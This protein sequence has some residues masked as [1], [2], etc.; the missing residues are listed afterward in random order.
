MLTSPLKRILYSLL[1]I[2]DA[3][4]TDYTAA[5]NAQES[6]AATP[7]HKVIQDEAPCAF[8]LELM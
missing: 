8:L 5:H 2:H 3:V 7:L 6:M 1:G 4:I